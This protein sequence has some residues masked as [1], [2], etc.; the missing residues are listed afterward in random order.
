MRF[1]CCRTAACLHSLPLRRRRPVH[2]PP[3]PPLAS[4]EPSSFHLAAHF[5][6][7]LLSSC[8][9]GRIPPSLTAAAAAVMSSSSSSGSKSRVWS[10]NHSSAAH[11]SA[12]FCPDCQRSVET[13]AAESEEDNASTATIPLQFAMVVAGCPRP[14]WWLRAASLQ[15]CRA[16]RSAI[17]GPVE[18]GPAK[19]A[20]R[21]FA[22]SSFSLLLLR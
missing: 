14:T 17:A 1:C 21:R 4:L 3:H 22:H 7:A 2:P 19:V 12:L 9:F 8:P 16:W 6:G 11:A 10:F 5:T 18:L 15:D 20:H 13:V